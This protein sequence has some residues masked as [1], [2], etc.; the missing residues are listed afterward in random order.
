MTRTEPVLAPQLHPGEP[1]QDDARLR[2]VLDW[3][4]HRGV[5]RT[6]TPG[7]VARGVELDHAEAL[8]RDRL[9]RVLKDAYAGRAT[10]HVGDYAHELVDLVLDAYNSLADDDP[11]RDGCSDPWAHAEGG[12]DV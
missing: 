1:R 10:T 12:H 3:L 11:C 8:T 4:E 9:A 6:P 7:T 2:Q 5:G